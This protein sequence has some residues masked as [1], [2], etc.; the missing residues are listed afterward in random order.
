MKRRQHKKAVCRVKGCHR[1]EQEFHLLWAA[2]ITA[3][4]QAEARQ[5]IVGPDSPVILANDELFSD[6]KVSK[7]SVG[8]EKH[9][10]NSKEKRKQGCWEEALTATLVW[11]EQAAALRPRAP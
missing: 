8:M 10:S 2:P 3:G 11:L 9:S 7:S 4:V 1:D 6:V 5:Q